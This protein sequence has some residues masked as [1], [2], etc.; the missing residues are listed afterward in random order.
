MI[1]EPRCP[2]KTS[3]SFALVHD[4]KTACLLSCCPRSFDL[5]GRGFT[6][7]AGSVNRAEGVSPSS[8]A[9]LL[10][11]AVEPPGKLT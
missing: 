3:K 10:M 5:R 11:K 6:Q 7:F 4:I 1:D 8:R 2:K 9:L